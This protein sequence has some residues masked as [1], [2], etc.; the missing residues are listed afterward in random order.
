MRTALRLA[1]LVTCAA[2]GIGAAV[3]LAAIRAPAADQARPTPVAAV[4]RTAPEL[5]FPRP[6]G[7]TGP[8]AAAAR[9]RARTPR[10]RRDD[11]PEAPSPEPIR[12]AAAP[13]MAPAA[14][15]AGAEPTGLPALM[16]NAAQLLQQNPQAVEQMLGSPQVQQ[17]L[18]D[19]RNSDQLL[20]SL[21]PAP[22][23]AAAPGTSAPPAPASAAPR[24]REELPPQGAPRSAIRHAEGDDRLT[25]ILQDEDLRKVLEDLSDQ[26]GLNILCSSSV[27]GKVSASLKDVDVHGALDAILRSTG[28]IARREGKFIYVGTPEDFAAMRTALDTLGTR[29]YR[30]NYVTAKELQTLVTP[31]LTPTQGKISVTS[32]SAVGIANDETTAGGD[33]F[34]SGEAVLVQDYEAVL[35]QVDQ[36]VREIDRKPLQ[37]AIEAM[38]LSVTLNDENRF[39]VNFQ[40]LRNT[41]NLRLGLGE[42][43]TGPVNGQ[44]TPVP[45][46][47]TTSP[48]TSVGANGLRFAYLNSSVAVLIN[49]LETIGDLNVIATPRLTCLN[50]QKAEILIGSQIG[51][52]TT[53]T[54]QTFATQTVQFLDVGTQLRLRPFISSDGTIRMEVHPELSQGTV[55][56]A[57]VPSKTLTQV[58]TNIQCQDGHTVIIGGLMQEELQTNSSQVPVVGSLPVVGALFR[59]RTERIVRREILVLV[60]PRIIYDDAS[61]QEGLAGLNSSEQRQATNAERLTKFSRTSMSRRYLNRAQAALADGRPAMAARFAELAVVF[62][63]NNGEAIALRDSFDEGTPAARFSRLTPPPTGAA[64][65]APNPLDGDTLPPWLLG[66]LQGAGTLP[67]APL[68]PRDPGIPGYGRVLVPQGVPA[69]E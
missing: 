21:Q 19:P 31:L 24:P 69:D 2:G 64:P 39:G 29:V 28:F 62:D 34:A 15:P 57:G 54:T 40:L 17:L 55:S 8:E 3:V 53:T 36:V 58:T 16:L 41:E 14:A 6:G 66:D 60:T 25:M 7:G 13:A 27:Q 5:D 42:F 59:N 35:T 63:P 23:S 68:H 4:Q 51:Y 38:I 46:A 33:A 22:A 56:A 50:K 12:L 67:D 44:D 20:K 49:A 47:G 45:A 9:S 26:G 61:S 65:L 32:A 10:P 11:P 1:L 37:V 30:P 48:F 43:G 52:I 18:A